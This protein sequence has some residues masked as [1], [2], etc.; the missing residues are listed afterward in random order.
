MV[1]EIEV[2]VAV[3]QEICGLLRE[4]L[5]FQRLTTLHMMRE[6]AARELDDNEC[7]HV[8]EASVGSRSTREVARATHLSDW[9]VRQVWRRL[10]AAGLMHEDPAVAGRYVPTF[11]LDELR[12]TLRR[13]GE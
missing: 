13:A 3:L 5:R 9:K 4:Q 2:P 8:L 11:G 10:A 1:T 7:W 6:C 12:C